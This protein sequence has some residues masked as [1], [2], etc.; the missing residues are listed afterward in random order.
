MQGA[1]NILGEN[2]TLKESIE[3]LRRIGFLQDVR[4]LP[5]PQ[6]GNDAKLQL[7][8][9]WGTATYLVEVQPKIAAS[10]LPGLIH[11]FR[12]QSP[13]HRLL[14]TS[15][16][17]PAL[18]EQLQE[19]RIEFLDAAG[20]AYLDRPIYLFVFGKKPKRKSFRP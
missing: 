8:G 3:A 5:I 7:K 11:R 13:E 16:V 17:P 12:H 19:R 18:A 10:A 4:L 2:I 9:E 15:F 1:K 6:Q 20:N 14:V